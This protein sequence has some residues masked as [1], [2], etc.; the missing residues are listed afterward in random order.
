MVSSTTYVRR[1]GVWHVSDRGLLRVVPKESVPLEVREAEAERQR[2]IREAAAPA[3]ELINRAERTRSLALSLR[4]AEYESAV[5]AAYVPGSNPREFRV[6]GFI[7][8]ARLFALYVGLNLLLLDLDRAH[9]WYGSV[10]HRNN[11]VLL[12]RGHRLRDE[13]TR[14]SAEEGDGESHYPSLTTRDL[15]VAQGWTRARAA[16]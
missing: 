16:A 6:E 12:E 1:D 5:V 9:E 3:V 4:D 2:K 8:P 14:R 7:L 10:Y 13:G 11:T 15:A